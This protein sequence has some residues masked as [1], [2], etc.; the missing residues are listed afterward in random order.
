MAV[1][2][3]ISISQ[4][5]LTT[6]VTLVGDLDLAT[7]DLLGG[8]LGELVRAGRT[9]LL[10]DTSDLRFCDLTG[11]DVL[12]EGR[13]AAERAGGSLHLTG[14]H[15]V[16]RRVLDVVHLHPVLY[17]HDVVDL[18]RHEAGDCLTAPLT[19]PH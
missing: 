3:E 18:E 1:Q 5:S 9:T 14:V 17:P 15:G 4:H 8:T 13:S 7:A 11:V 10:V 2:L 12:M 16:L 19:A 6:V